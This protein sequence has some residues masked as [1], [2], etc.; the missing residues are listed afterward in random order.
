MKDEDEEEEQERG[1]VAPNMEAG[2]AHLHAISDPRQR[3]KGKES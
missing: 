2:G 3:M 1:R